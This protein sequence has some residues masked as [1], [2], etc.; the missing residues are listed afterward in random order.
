MLRQRLDSLYSLVA[1]EKSFNNDIG[2]PKTLLRCTSRTE[3]CILEMGTNHPGEIARLA[4]IAAPDIGI[5]TMIGSAHLEAF[6]DR[7]G[8]LEEKG[9]LLDALPPGGTAILGCEGHGFG[10]LAERAR[11]AI[12]E[13]GTVLCFGSLEKARF[14]ASMLRPIHGGV[15]FELDY[16]WEGQTHREALVLPR[17]GQHDVRNLLAALAA[18]GALG[19]DP[20]EVLADVESLLPPPRRLQAR[21]ARSGA[22]LLD[23]TYNANPESLLAALSVLDSW[24]GVQRRILVL[25]DMLELGSDSARIHGELGEGLLERV[26]LLITVGP[27]AAEAARPRLMSETVDREA[28][29]RCF[30]EALEALPLLEETL[31]PGD[32]VLF[33]AS[34]GIGLDRLVDPL[35]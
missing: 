20:A 10:H 8:V 35:L 23:D 14:R 28:R 11:R 26:D 9:A 5:I 15:A 6:H 3:V 16:E 17:P 29:T 34:R 32:L 1:S 13:E 21:Q 30:S 4:E 31:R 18:V 27:L 25:G 12:G 7:A 24:Q 19:T 2:L 33:K 22:I